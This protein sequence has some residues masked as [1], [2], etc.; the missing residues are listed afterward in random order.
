MELFKDREMTFK[1][2][3]MKQKRNNKGSRCDN[4]GNSQIIKYLNEIIGGEPVYDNANIK[5]KY[6][7]I[8][9][10]VLTEVLLRYYDETRRN[11]KRWFFNIEQAMIRDVSK[12]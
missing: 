1:V 9:L 10:C 11:G 5:D 4:L 2:K 12:M 6:T 8:S 3:D 7:K